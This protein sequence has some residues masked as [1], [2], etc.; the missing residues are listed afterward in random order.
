[1]TLNTVE[2]EDEFEFIFHFDDDL[3]QEVKVR[4]KKNKYEKKL[5][6]RQRLEGEQ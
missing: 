6:N 4:M 2:L 5:H 1:M 3:F